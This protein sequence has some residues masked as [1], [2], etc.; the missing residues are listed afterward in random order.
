[1]KETDS[2]VKHPCRLMISASWSWVTWPRRKHTQRG[3]GR[4]RGGGRGRGERGERE[5]ETGMTVVIPLQKRQNI[6]YHH[7][8]EK[9]TPEPLMVSKTKVLLLGRIPLR[10]ETA[11]PSMPQ[12]TGVLLRHT[13]SRN[14]KCRTL[15][16]YTSELLNHTGWNQKQGWNQKHVDTAAV[17]SAGNR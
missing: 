10:K 3:R 1:M 16:V 13:A 4:R 11:A 14:S 9:E 2:G 15:R 8:V 7:I 12:N 6:Q 5:R 17:S